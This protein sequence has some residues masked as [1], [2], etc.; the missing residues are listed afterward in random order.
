MSN[1]AGDTPYFTFDNDSGSKDISITKISYT[2]SGG[3]LKELTY[4]TDWYIYTYSGNDFIV[5]K[6]MT[7]STN[8]KISVECKLNKQLDNGLWAYF[9]Y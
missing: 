6:N 3:T 9:G 8:D 4:N 5:F 1:Y 2:P 7:I